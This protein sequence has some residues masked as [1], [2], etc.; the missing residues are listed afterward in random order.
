MYHVPNNPNLQSAFATIL[1]ACI[2]RGPG[3]GVSIGAIYGSY[4]GVARG[5]IVG[6]LV[7]GIVGIV[8]SMMLA[9]MIYAWQ[10]L[11]P[12][13]NQRHY[14]LLWFAPLMIVIG[15]LLISYGLLGE[16]LG[17]NHYLYDL[18]LNSMQNTRLSRLVVWP[19]VIISA[20]TFFGLPIILS[21]IQISVP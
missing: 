13:T 12:T 9:T 1:D 21:N 2:Q 16:Q 19:S 5:F 8:G 15:Y 18:M 4:L 6:S 17:L 10:Q 20:S 3:L 11:F 14:S 7:G